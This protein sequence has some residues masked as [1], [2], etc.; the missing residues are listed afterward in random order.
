MGRKNKYSKELK[1]SIVKRYLEGEGSTIFLAKEINTAANIVS[2]WVKKY[3]AFGESAFDIS[4]TNA[5]YTK[6]LKK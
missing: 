4:N 5:S 2:S 1:L 6:N 3:N